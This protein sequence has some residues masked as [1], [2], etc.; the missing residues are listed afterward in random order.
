MFYAD[1]ICVGVSQRSVECSLLRGKTINVFT[2]A[3]E[4]K[5]SH[6]LTGVAGG[7]IWHSFLQLQ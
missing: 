5:M 4:S 7:E 1:K 2:V 3:D 6:V